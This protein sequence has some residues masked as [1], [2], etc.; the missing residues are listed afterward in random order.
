[1]ET[2]V[3][4]T[5][6]FGLKKFVI[7][8]FVLL[9]GVSMCVCSSTNSYFEVDSIIYYGLVAWSDFCDL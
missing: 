3:Y 2:K 4:F 7:W 9:Q 5:G 6:I 8:C 1:M